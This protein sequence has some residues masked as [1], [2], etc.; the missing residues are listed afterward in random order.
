MRMTLTSGMLVAAACAVLPA[1]AL[2][3]ATGNVRGTVVDCRTEARLPHAQIL[4][5]DA[6]TGTLVR[7]LSADAKGN[8]SALGLPDG[9]YL[10]QLQSEDKTGLHLMSVE[11]GDIGDY[12]LGA[13]S[14]GECKPFLLPTSPGTQDQ[15]TIR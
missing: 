14:N 2:A 10:V 1:T 4:F 12:R 15:T 8:Y 6:R 3:V 13:A 9:R 7:R 5:R 11:P